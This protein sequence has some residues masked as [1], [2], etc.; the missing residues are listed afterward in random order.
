LCKGTCGE[1]AFK[2]STRLQAFLRQP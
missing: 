1:L 2:C